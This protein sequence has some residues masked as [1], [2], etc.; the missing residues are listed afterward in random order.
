MQLVNNPNVLFLDEPTSGL[1]SFTSFLL[2]KHLKEIANKGKAIIF[3]IHQ[4]SSDIFNLFDRLMILAKGSLT[5]QGPTK[6]SVNYF[7]SINYEC[8]SYSTPSDYFMDLVH[9]GNVNHHKI[10]PDLV[11]KYNLKLKPEIESKTAQ[12]AKTP[13]EF[14]KN[15]LTWA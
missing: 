13:I 11:E 2:I 7:S 9:A 3:T 15:P 4:P 14:H 1:D 8:P 5:Y 6:S 12:P 10:I